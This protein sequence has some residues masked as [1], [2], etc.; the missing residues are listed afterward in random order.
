MRPV[1]ISVIEDSPADVRW[2]KMIL[3]EVGL[4]HRL[5]VAEDGEQAVECLLREGRYAGNPS[6]DLIFLDMHLP[7]FDGLEV[8]RK[9][10]GSALLPVCM[11]T[12]SERER[13]LM[14]AHFKVA[15]EYR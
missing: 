9:V 10:P 8:L 3:S 14:A 6:A 1:E 13:G 11:L 7:M 15:S 12:S 4:K 2:L 5:T